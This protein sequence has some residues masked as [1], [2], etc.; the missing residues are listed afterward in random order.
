MP[1]LSSEPTSTPEVAA[2]VKC[3]KYQTKIRKRFLSHPS[4]I[5]AL[6]WSVSKS[7]LYLWLDWCDPGMW[8]FTQTLQMLRNI[9][10]PLAVVSFD[11]HVVAV[12]Q[13]K[14]HFVDAGRK[15][16]LCCWCKI[17]PKCNIDFS[18]FWN[19]SI[20]ISFDISCFMDLFKLY[21]D[22]SMFWYGF[23]KDAIWICWSCCIGFVRVVILISRHLPKKL[24]DLWPTFQSLLKLLLWTKG[25]DWVK[26]FNAL[27]LLCLWQCFYTVKEFLCSD[28]FG[29]NIIIQLYQTCPNS[30]FKK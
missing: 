3:K 5:I 13:I 7:V 18:K 2:K 17:C 15:Q 11:S 9:S 12:E 6:P 20:C 21:M 19:E 8:R 4:P 25:V 27:G 22:L 14:S 29:K 23:V 16:K 26:A 30:F 1:P 10:L 24:A 28:L